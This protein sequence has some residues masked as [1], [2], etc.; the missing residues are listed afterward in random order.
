MSDFDEWKDV[1]DRT[2]IAIEWIQ[3]ERMRLRD[4]I[5][6]NNEAAKNGC[7]SSWNVINLMRIVAAEDM[8]IDNLLSTIIS[9]MK[10]EKKQLEDIVGVINNE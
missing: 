4:V 7:F 10:I 9:M 8:A 5:M 3:K 2:G 6:I 1:I